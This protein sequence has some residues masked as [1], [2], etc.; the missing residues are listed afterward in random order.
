M[1]YECIPCA[2]YRARRLSIMQSQGCNHEREVRPGVLAR[3]AK[4][5]AAALMP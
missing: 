5:D 2:L 1:I 3:L 4:M